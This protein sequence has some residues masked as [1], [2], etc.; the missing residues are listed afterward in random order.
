M[1]SSAPCE[2]PRV[3]IKKKHAGIVKKRFK[4]S[5]HQKSEKEKKKKQRA[6]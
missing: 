3:R 1:W 6:P 2:I 4:Y 5:D